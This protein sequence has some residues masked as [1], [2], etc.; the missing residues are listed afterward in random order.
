MNDNAGRSKIPATHVTRDRHSGW[1]IDPKFLSK[2]VLL[3]SNFKNCF[4]NYSVSILLGSTNHMCSLFVNAQI[5]VVLKRFHVV[6]K[7]LVLQKS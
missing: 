6:R 2:L 5:V 1:E 4:F 7:S 3:S